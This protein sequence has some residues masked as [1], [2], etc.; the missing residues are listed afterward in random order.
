MKVLKNFSR[1]QNR[2]ISLLA[3]STL[4]PV[5]VLGW[6]SISVA[7]NAIT[8]LSLQVIDKETSKT[9]EKIN[10][11]LDNVSQDVLFLRGMPPVSGIIRARE[12]GG[13]DPEDKSSYLQWINRLNQIFV[14][15]MESRPQY[16][17]LSYLDEKGNEMVKINSDNETITVVPAKQMQNEAKTDYFMETMKLKLGGVYVSQV[18]LNREG[19]KIESPHH[20][21]L[22]VSTPIYSQQGNKRGILVV[23]VNANSFLEINTEDT[24][25]KTT[26][27]VVNQNGY[28]LSHPNSEKTFGFEFN[29]DER[30]SRDYPEEIAAQLLSGGKGLI[31][32][33][34]PQLL[35]YYTLYPNKNTKIHPLIFVSQ[36]QKSEVFASIAQLR[37][38]AFL[39]T[40]LSLLAVLIIGSFI[41]RSLLRLIQQL[42][43]VISSFSLQVLSTLEEQERLS[44]QQSSSVQETTVTMDQLSNSSQQSALQ[45]EAAAAGARLAL[46]RVAD[47]NQAVKESLEEMETLKIKVEAI[48]QEIGRLSEQTRQIGTI[49]KLVSDLANQTNMLALNAAVEAV[50]AGDYGK[51]FAVVAKEIRTLADQS[52]KSAESIN[53]LVANLQKAIESTVEVSNEGTNN[54]DSSV[55]IVK[56]TAE[57]FNGLAGGMNRIV[58]NSQQIAGNAKQQALAIQQV[59]DAM[60]AINQGAAESASGIR[61]TKVGTQQL[62]EAAMRLRAAV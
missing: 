45:A 19:G 7:T 59:L 58:D 30:I 26:F 20:P 50:R 62:T 33:G 61:Q 49:S 22:R 13:I 36:L 46:D 12:N 60:N 8:D 34:T 54:V 1:F 31:S 37:G 3:I 11:F 32:E 23:N 2:L 27:F 40:F 4:I 47:G 9:A 56:K 57:A 43:A 55:K 39:V 48:A 44:S 53:S 29:K 14:A 21:V 35:S 15:L 5:L 41:I 25:N 52:K 51:E 18:N 42:T 10:N 6:Y 16:Y 28:Y 24:K 38:A 17:Q